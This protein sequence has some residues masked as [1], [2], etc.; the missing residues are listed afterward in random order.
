MPSVRV[1]LSSNVNLPSEQFKCVG[2]GFGA[3]L[4]GRG[5]PP[6][7]TPLCSDVVAVETRERIVGMG[8]WGASFWYCDQRASKF[9][10][11]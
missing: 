8:G 7:L 9:D 11:I 2:A 4:S 5:A 10:L 3:A 6:P 1:L